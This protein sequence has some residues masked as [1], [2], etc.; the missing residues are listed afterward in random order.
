[1][2]EPKV[3]EKAPDFTLKSTSSEMVSLSQ[4]KGRKNVL[5]AFFPLAF[6][7][8][9]TAENCAFTEDYS[10]FEAAYTEVLP[11]SVDSTPTQNEF[12]TKYK[13]K[14]HLLSDFKRQ[15]G[16]AY[17]VLDEDLFFTKRAYFLVD[18]AGVLRFK[19]VEAELGHSRPN[20]ELLAE[21]NKVKG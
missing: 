2:A 16:R 9:C 17:G 20:S 3:G 19:H 7:G 10:K 18:K 15:A 13:M 12:R 21:I 1:M 14:Q 11:V 6:T 5:I 4:F 8:V